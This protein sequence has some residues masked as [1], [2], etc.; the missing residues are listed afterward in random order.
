ME[1]IPVIGGSLASLVGDYVPQSTER[2][3]DKA[4]RFLETEVARLR[5]RV[6]VNAVN[7]DE[8]AELFKACYFTIV[9]THHE[10]KLRAAAAVI[11]NILLREGDPEKLSYAELDHF[12]R[13]VDGLSIG[14]I[15]VLGHAYDI[16]TTHRRPA[17]E[18]GS[19]RLD[20]RDLRPK[21][22]E[23]DPHFLMGLVGELNAQNLLH[24]L[25]SPSVRT[26]E[27]GNYPIELT[28]HGARFVERLLRRSGASGT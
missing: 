1:A 18:P 6:D 9:R 7:K 23:I 20:F 2:S 21:M 12:T 14:A 8:F 27:Y 19:V 13:C 3:R 25:G 15:R 16:A 4:L 5:E 22:P 28:P 11:A 26:P 10:E 24:L 17:A